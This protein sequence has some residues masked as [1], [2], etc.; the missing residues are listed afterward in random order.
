[1]L[2]GELGRFPIELTIKSRMIG[3]WNRLVH[4]KET[5]LSF[6]LH[7]S[8][9]VSKWQNHIK[10]IFNQ[11][12]R[13]DFWIEQ[14]SP[15]TSLSQL[16]KKILMDQYVQNWLARDSQSLKAITY[17]SFKHDFELEKYLHAYLANNISDFSNLELATINFQWKRAG[18]TARTLEKENVSCVHW[19]TLE[20]SS[21][22]F[23]N[24]RILTL[25]DGNMLNRIILFART[26]L[27]SANFYRLTIN[28]YLIGYVCL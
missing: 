25:K 17:F 11:I 13:P 4:S 28:Q 27:N 2:Y 16:V 12:G 10:N 21:I 26:C 23:V 18:G 22:I 24:V 8:D 19:T 14:I 20:M 15:S 5:K 9:T 3:Y 6:L 1:M 7:S